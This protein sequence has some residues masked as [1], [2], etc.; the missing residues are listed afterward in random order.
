MEQTIAYRK[1]RA[2]TWY[3]RFLQDLKC[4]WRWALLGLAIA[5]P[6]G[7]P[8]IFMAGSAIGNRDPFAIAWH[9]V[10]AIIIFMGMPAVFFR[11]SRND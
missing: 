6:L 9:S 11:M 2:A 7:T 8:F 1:E 4:C 10:T 5:I 3:G